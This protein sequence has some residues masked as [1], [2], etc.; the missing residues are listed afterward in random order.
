MPS[1]ATPDPA[2]PGPAAGD[3]SSR[4]LQTLTV[5]PSGSDVGGADVGGAD[6]RALQIAI[7]AVAGRG[8]GT[9]LVQPGD[10]RLDGP[11]PIVSKSPK[12]GRN[13]PCPC[14]SGMKFKKCC[15]KKTDDAMLD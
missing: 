13:E 8:G 15:L 14:G 3:L 11:A 6:G 12:T 1:P 5:G 2:A 9:V 10:Y 4:P 7:D